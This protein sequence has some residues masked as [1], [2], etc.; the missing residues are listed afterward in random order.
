MRILGNNW[1]FRIEK[2]VEERCEGRRRF[3]GDPMVQGKYANRIHIQRVR[4]RMGLSPG[5]PVARMEQCPVAPLPAYTKVD[6][7]RQ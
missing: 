7:T 4:K 3:F 2:V 6:Q 1:Y 5:H